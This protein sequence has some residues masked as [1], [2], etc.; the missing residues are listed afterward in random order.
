MG[1]SNNWSHRSLPACTN[2]GKEHGGYMSSSEFTQGSFCSS[3]C[4]KR[5]TAKVRNGMAPEEETDPGR[6]ELRNRIRALERRLPR[7]LRYPNRYTG[8]QA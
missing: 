6:Q 2:C 7:N 8:E 3:A 5:Y 4:G 1:C